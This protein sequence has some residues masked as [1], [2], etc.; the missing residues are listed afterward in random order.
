MKKDDFKQPVLLGIGFV[1]LLL[2]VGRTV[3]AQTS[4]N[5]NLTWSTIDG[6]GGSSTSSNFSLSGTVG[7]PD[8]GRSSSDNL[9]LHGGFWQCIT[10]PVALPTIANAS[11]DVQLM[12]TSTATTVNI[13]RAVNDPFFTPDVPY[14]SDED[15]SPWLDTLDNDE[16]GNVAE[17][18]T[19]LIR[20]KGDCGE[21]GNSMRLGEFDFAIVPG[22]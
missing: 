8:A 9:T 17:N 10:A 15:G 12:W 2:L 7:Q 16:I 13:Y 6:G 4:S 20:A 14:D 5:F 1:V 11:G 19:Y 3:L 18:H 21:S 22:S